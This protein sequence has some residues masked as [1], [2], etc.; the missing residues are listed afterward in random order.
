M[1]KI[2]SVVASVLLVALLL[3]G[4]GTS[5]P[6][7]TANQANSS[8]NSQAGNKKIGAL[9]STTSIPPVQ[10]IINKAE[11]DAKTAGAEIV[12]MDAQFDPF[13]QATQAKNLL[14]Q[15]VGAVLVNVIDPE[16]IVPS[17]KQFHDAGIPVII[18]TLPV[19]KQADPYITS[20]VGPDNIAAGKLAGELMAEALGSAG[21][22]VVIIEGAPGITVQDRTAGFK[23]G[24][25]GKNI[26]VL[27]I[28]TSQW[29]RAKALSIMQDFLSKYPDLNGVFVHN[30]DM[31][32]GAIQAIKQA[33][34]TDQ[35][36][37]I[38]FG[39]TKEAV[40]ALEQGD[41]YGTVTED[42]VWT[43]Q[44]EIEVALAAIEKKPVEKAIYVPTGKLTRANL[45]G[46]TPTY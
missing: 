37:V 23:E 12:N 13:T 35:V 42:L 10:V 40:K 28:Q 22:N 41:M 44:K 11:Q 27:N 39:G 3:T 8:G 9:W 18:G 24:L 43:A 15:R 33:G 45:A 34:K 21:G 30:D 25:Q 4:C 29:D 46:Y 2:T 17:L 7:N 16:G 32:M 5:N 14:S 36:K 31:A 6:A 26:N 20:F 1:K 38:G 19:S